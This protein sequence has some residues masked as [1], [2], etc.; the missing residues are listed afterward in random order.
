MKHKTLL[1]VVKCMQ[2]CHTEVELGKSLSLDAERSEEFRTWK[3]EVKTVLRWLKGAFNRPN[4][5][6]KCNV[7]ALCRWCQTMAAYIARVRE[8]P[9]CVFTILLIH[10]S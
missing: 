1:A 6:K 5:T 9:N 4:A 10:N 3:E 2:E 7:L 8:S